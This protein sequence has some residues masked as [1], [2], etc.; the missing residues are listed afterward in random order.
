[1][2]NAFAC[3]FSFFFLL[4]HIPPPSSRICFVFSLSKISLTKGGVV[5]GWRNRGGG[6]ARADT[7]LNFFAFYREKQERD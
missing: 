3:F 7:Q 5:E 2:Q 4:V 6:R 1:M